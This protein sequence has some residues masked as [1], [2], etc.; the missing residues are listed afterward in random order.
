LLCLDMRF[1]AGRPLAIDIP[2]P[3]RQEHQPRDRTLSEVRNCRGT[4]PLWLDPRL[5][6]RLFPNLFRLL[7]I[8]QLATLLAGTRLV[9][10]EAPGLHSIWRSFELS[11]SNDERLP[12]L[13]YR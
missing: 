6:A 2:L 7:P 9:G 3:F 5:A 13:T 12:H 10:M 4:I 11:E 1:E 8:Q